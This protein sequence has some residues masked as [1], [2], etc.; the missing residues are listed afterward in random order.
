MNFFII[1]VIF[2]HFMHFVI[3]LNLL[4]FMSFK[5]HFKHK[6]KYLHNTKTDWLPLKFRLVLN[7]E[8]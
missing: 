4:I 3:F 2:R 5:Q 7:I 8:N 6:T 1:A